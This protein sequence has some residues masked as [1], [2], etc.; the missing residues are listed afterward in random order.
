MKSNYLKEKIIP[1]V[2]LAGLA[3]GQPRDQVIGQLGIP[4]EKKEAEV[5]SF[6]EYPGLTVCLEND[7]I[8]MLIAEY[9]YEGKT[10]DGSYVGMTWLELKSKYSELKFDV[11]NDLWVVPGLDGVWF[12]IA[13][14]AQQG[15]DP[16][17]PPYVSEVYEVIDE[18]HA[19]VRSIYVM[20]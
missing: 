17:R 1:K 5:L 7:Q 3:I 15:E 14:P 12:D 4:Q 18:E 10:P 6:L 13:R 16:I 20:R 11:E 2:G 19:F 8:S 9:G